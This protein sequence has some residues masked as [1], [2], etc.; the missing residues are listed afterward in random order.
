MKPNKD[1]E[2]QDYTAGYLDGLDDGLPTPRPWVIWVM[3]VGVALL[4]ALV[5]AVGWALLA[6]M[7]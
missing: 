6:Q 2:S 3:V 4:L 7:A 5:A 1:F